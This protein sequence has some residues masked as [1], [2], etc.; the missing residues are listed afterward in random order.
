[1]YCLYITMY[2]VNFLLLRRSLSSSLYAIL[3]FFFFAS[4]WFYLVHSYLNSFLST[5]YF[6]FDSYIVWVYIDLWQVCANRHH[7]QIHYTRFDLPV[8]KICMY[9]AKQNNKPIPFY[10]FIFIRNQ[11]KPLER[12]K[13]VSC[14]WIF[15]HFFSNKYIKI[16]W[17]VLEA[18]RYFLY[19]Y[20]LQF[21]T[22]TK[23][24][25]WMFN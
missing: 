18:V 5:Y 11:C 25:D 21:I 22:T 19:T 12:E 4:I 10:I 17:L 15:F 1:M 3:I 16:F 6:T 24:A 23:N 20:V 8:R 7:T 9:I 14:T 13:R 2:T